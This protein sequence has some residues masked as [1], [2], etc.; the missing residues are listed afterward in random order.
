MAMEKNFIKFL[1][2]AGARFVVIK[3]LR[4]SGGIWVNLEGTDILIDP[5][6]G[7]LVRAL[8]SK[9]KLSPSKLKA[10][11]ISHRHIDHCN[12]ASIMIEAMTEGGTHKKGNL[13]IPLDALN[14]DSVIFPHTLNYLP[15]P[16][17]ILQEGKN[18]SIQNINIYTP[19]KHHHSVETYGCIIESAKTKIAYIADTLYF[20]ALIEAYKC[21]ILIMNIVLLENK[22]GIDHLS[23]VDA[24]I[25]IKEIKPQ[26][27]ILTHFGMHMIKAKP[28][29]L[30]K[31]LQEKLAIK[32]IAANDGLVYNL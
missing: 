16:P 1:G 7:S 3:Q 2:T 11:Y 18:Y 25:L 6:P 24:E 14:K 9:P 4:A 12:D 27:A 8:N 21:D 10:I 22:I 32:I 23:L 17:I 15:Q 20:D 30:A 31:N 19:I 26:V 13:L 29:E 28:W 5:G